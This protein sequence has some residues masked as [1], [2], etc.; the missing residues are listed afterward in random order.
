MNELTLLAPAKINLCLS[1]LGKRPDGYHEVEMLMQAVGLFDRVTV[2]LIAGGGVT[3]SCEASGVPSGADNIA[4][5]AARKILEHAG[6]SQGMAITLEKN[7]PVAAGLGGGSSDAAAVLV[8]CNVLLGLGLERTTLAEVG[9]GLGMDVPFFLH[10][11]TA[12]ARGRGEVVEPLLPPTKFWVL[13]V[14]PRFGTS[15]ADVYKGLN[16]E[17]TKKV[18]CNKIARLSVGQIARSLHNDLET[19]TAAAHPVIGE[20]EQALLEAGALGARMSGSGPTVFG[21]FENGAA[22]RKAENTLGTRGW[23][24]YSAEILTGTLYGEHLGALR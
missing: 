2:R 4:V 15:T 7:I 8:A 13:L 20:M 24:L 22:C 1:V 16:L 11:P 5:R 6:S 17:L 3:M 10:G 9:T 23:R 21:I 14:N 12:L 19:V 18:D